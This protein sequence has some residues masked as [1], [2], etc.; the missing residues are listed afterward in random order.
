MDGAPPVVV[1]LAKKKHGCATRHRLGTQN[2]SYL[3]ECSRH[4]SS[5]TLGSIA[6][7]GRSFL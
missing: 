7:T 5:D 6:L 2:E 4:Q 3:N 1:G